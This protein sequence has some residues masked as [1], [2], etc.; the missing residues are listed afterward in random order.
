MEPVCRICETSV[1]ND[2]LFPDIC[3]SCAR[4]DWGFW[5]LLKVARYG[6]F[7]GALVGIFWVTGM[8]RAGFA[9]P[10]LLLAVGAVIGAL[11]GRAA[12][13]GAAS[14]VFQQYLMHVREDLAEHERAQEAEKF[15]YVGMLSAFQG[16]T[17]YAV[18][19]LKL[20]RDHGWAGWDR[21]TADPQF[22]AFCRLPQVR[23]IMETPTG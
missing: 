7:V 20:A 19:M 8:D 22:A 18:R 11:V 16:K 5:R 14:F 4:Y 17:Q 2:R 23:R 13:E 15:F 9:H 12:T 6:M 10:T 1:E 3:G 21:L